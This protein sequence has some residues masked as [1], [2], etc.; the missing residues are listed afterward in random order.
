MTI[1]HNLRGRA[2]T[3]ASG[4]SQV[5][6]RT[7][8]HRSDELKLGGIGEGNFGARNGDLAVL[9]DLEIGIQIG[10]VASSAALLLRS[11]NERHPKGLANGSDVVG[12][13]Y[14]GHVNSV[15]LAI[16]KCMAME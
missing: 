2:A 15:M 8:V 1:T 6:A 4:I 7:G 9:A 5:T 10:R 11:A 12:R 3:F 16:S 13:H 14:M